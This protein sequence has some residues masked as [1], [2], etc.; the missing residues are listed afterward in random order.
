[1]KSGTTS[2]I[3]GAI[4]NTID[5]IAN[6][7]KNNNVSIT[8]NFWQTELNNIDEIMSIDFGSIKIKN[9]TSSDTT[10]QQ[11]GVKFD[12]ISQSSQFITHN[13]IRDILSSSINPEETD[14]V[15]STII[16]NFSDEKIKQIISTALTSIS[17]N[18]GNTDNEIDSFQKELGFLQ[19]L[20]N[21][22][23]TSNIITESSSENMNDLINL[24][25]YLDQ[26]AYNIKADETDYIV[27]DEDS[28]SKWITRQVISQLIVDMFNMSRDETVDNSNQQAVAYANLLTSIITSIEEKGTKY[29]Y[30]WQTELKFVGHLL[31]LK[32]TTLQTSN[33][34]KPLD[35]IAFNIYNNSATTT[36]YADIQYDGVDTNSDSIIDYYRAVSYPIN[37]ESLLDYT[38]E[39]AIVTNSIFLSREIL[40]DNVKNIFNNFKE[41]GVLENEI[42]VDAIKNDL[43]DNLSENINISHSPVSNGSKFNTFTVAFGALEDLK[44]GLTDFYDLVDGKALNDIGTITGQI[45]ETLETNQENILYGVVTTRKLALLITNE[46]LELFELLDSNDYSSKGYLEDLQSYYTNNL[47][48]L[49]KESYNSTTSSI[50]DYDTPFQTYHTKY[51]EDLANLGL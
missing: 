25:K 13:R 11:L 21:I 29:V 31:D 23:V 36:A 44:T 45:D 38:N 26:M 9:P 18:I 14:S 16:D 41:D 32:N 39:T 42:S 6:D 50:D 46:V 30:Q 24:G 19:T 2:G 40:R 35:A 22:N 10:L 12:N 49:T 8:D 4:N 7:L 51:Q 33:I 47:N 27:Y 28:N 37:G 43:L 34:G 5:S 15:S 3:D 20:A 48:S 17:N 1:M